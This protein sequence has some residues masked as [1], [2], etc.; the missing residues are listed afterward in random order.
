MIGASESDTHVLRGFAALPLMDEVHALLLKLI[1]VR[2]MG[3][4][5]VM[6]LWMMLLLLLLLT[7]RRC[8]VYNPYSRSRPFDFSVYG[9]L[10]HSPRHDSVVKVRLRANRESSYGIV[11][12]KFLEEI[13]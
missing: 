9:V 6:S 1:H 8:R 12:V 3:K 5:T 13:I 7:R 2:V 4:L 10:L 11:R